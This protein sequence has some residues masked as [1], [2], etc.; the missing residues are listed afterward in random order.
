MIICLVGLLL[1]GCNLKGY[2]VSIY[3]NT[4]GIKHYN[5]TAN[6]LEITEA[7]KSGNDILVIKVS[8][9]INLGSVIGDVNYE[10]RNLYY[11][12]PLNYGTYT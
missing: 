10:S 12:N 8:S 1:V 9:V 6:Q 2:L 7:M 5:T 4:L 11:Y 3:T